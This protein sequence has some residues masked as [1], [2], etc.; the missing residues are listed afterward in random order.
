MTVFQHL[1]VNVV[2]GGAFFNGQSVCTNTEGKPAMPEIR[3]PRESLKL[4][5]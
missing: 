1:T 4:E 5:A 3:N 2:A